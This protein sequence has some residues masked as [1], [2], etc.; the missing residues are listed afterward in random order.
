M[1]RN[2]TMHLYNNL[3][4]YSNG[5][6]SQQYAVGPRKGS[7]IYSE[8]NYFG[9]GINY[10]FKDSGTSSSSGTVN[11]SGDSFNSTYGTER[12]SNEAGTTLFSSLADVYSYSAETA[13]TVKTNL[14]SEAGNGAVTIN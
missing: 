14:P 9:S 6:Y 1:V 4:E 10:A 3:Y 12:L 5:D 7:V 11:S 8:N 13:A 2:T